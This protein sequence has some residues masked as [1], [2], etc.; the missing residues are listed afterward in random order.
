MR[1]LTVLAIGLALAT[2]PLPAAGQTREPEAYEY[3]FVSQ[4]GLG[5]GLWT[6][7]GSAGFNQM[8]RLIGHI[9]VDRPEGGE[10]STGQYLLGLQIGPIGFGYRHDEFESGT[11][12]QGDAYTLSGG[13]SQGRNGLGVSRTWR[14]VGEPSQGSWEIGYVSYAAAGVSGGIVWRDI[15][16]PE[17]RDTVRDERLV[18]AISY[19]PRELPL[20]LS[21]QADY[22]L[23]GPNEFNAFRVGGTVRIGGVVDALALAQWSGEG[24]FDGFRIAAAIRQPRLTAVGG[25]GLSKGGDARTASAGV[26]IDV[27]RTR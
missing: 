22:R 27:P 12:A 5:S 23:G 7:P 6:N 10:W 20:S 19:R 4:P 17:V 24:D 8:T 16:S 15:G 1:H 18:G 13:L 3:A 14:Q 25:A 11:Y 9:T 2:A 26:S 21:L